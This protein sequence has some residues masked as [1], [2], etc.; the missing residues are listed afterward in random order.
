MIFVDEL[1]EARTR[2][3]DAVAT[4]DRARRERD[5][6]ALS[7]AYADQ[8]T[9]QRDVARISGH[10]YAERIDLGIRMDPGAPEPRVISDSQN[11]V[12]IF[13]VSG[14]DMAAKGMVHF[15][16]TYLTKFGGLNDEAIE[17]H[18]LHN[19][20][21]EPYATHVVRN[22]EWISEA[23]QANSVHPNHKAGWSER[24]EHFVIC[25]HDE[26]FECIAETWQAHTI[27]ATMADAMHQAVNRLVDS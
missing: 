22:S 14:Q 10:Q 25:F 23:E 16:G 7:A 13:Y 9:A 27:V 3:A 6:T 8:T 15:K 11:T 2:L 4:I 1:S 21:L 5:F 20:G 24:Y 18:P 12:V 26:T 17:G 19:H